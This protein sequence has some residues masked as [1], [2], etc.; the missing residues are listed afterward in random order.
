MQ[1]PLAAAFFLIDAFS[2]T[3]GG[4]GGP[5]LV[6]VFKTVRDRLGH[7]IHSHRNSINSRIDHTLGQGIAR[8]A[9]E[10]QA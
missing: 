5:D 7:A 10:M 1:E 3:P 4:G 9:H 2:E 6:A 8:E